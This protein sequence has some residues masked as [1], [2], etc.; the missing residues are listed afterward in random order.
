MGYSGEFFYMDNEH[1][2][3]IGRVYDAGLGAASWDSALDD[4]MLAVGADVSA[5]FVEDRSRLPAAYD[6]FALRGYPDYVTAAYSAHFAD[7]DIRLPAVRRLQPREA[8]VDDR[9]MPF[10][11]I[12]RSEIYNDFYRPIG[13]AH[14]MAVL[15]V[16]E[17]KRFG[18]FSVHR[19]INAGNFRPEEVALFEHLSPHVIRALQLQRQLARANGVAASL[20]A[21][22]DHFPI[23]V[24]LT[25]EQGLIVELNRAAEAL[26]RRPR[27]S[28]YR[29]SVPM[30][31]QH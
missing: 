5:L 8:Y 19:A 11:E 10:E 12:Q 25:D 1:A 2:H 3:L 22:L 17:G 29:Q 14:A 13:V 4:I 9:N 30:I 21:A 7:R 15:P 23:A 28:G 26:L 20:S 31:R 6:A 18:I 24:L 16:N 27:A